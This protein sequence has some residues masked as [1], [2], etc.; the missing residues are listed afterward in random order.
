MGIRLNSVELAGPEWTT[1]VN[2]ACDVVDSAI[3]YT[4]ESWGVKPEPRD[5]VG[6][7]YPQYPGESIVAIWRKNGDQI[8]TMPREVWDR[9]RRYA[10]AFIAKIRE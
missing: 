3:R 8:G 4:L 5:N 9:N 1:D 10:K 6:F 7:L 2:F